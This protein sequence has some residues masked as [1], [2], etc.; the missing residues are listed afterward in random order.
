[1]DTI[2]DYKIIEYKTVE[3]ETP[4]KLDQQ[5]KDLIAEGY[6]P[7]GNPYT[8]SK[9]FYQAMIKTTDLPAPGARRGF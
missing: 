4:G 8:A 3:G 7:Y 2:I 6:Q 5:I 9:Q 1:M